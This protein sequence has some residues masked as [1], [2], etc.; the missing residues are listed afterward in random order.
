MLGQTAVAGRNTNPLASTTRLR[1][2]KDELLKNCFD[3]PYDDPRHLLLAHNHMTLIGRAFLVSPTW[4]IP[5]D[6]ERGISF[7]DAEGKLS[8]AAVAEHPNGKPLVQMLK[9]G[10]AVEVLA[11]P[12]EVEEPQAAAVISRA[13][14]K[15]HEVAL[16]TTEL[17]A[18]AT[19]KGEIIR[20]M[21]KD[22][23]QQ[24]AYQ[25]VRAAVA[26]QLDTALEDPDLPELFDY[27]INAGVGQN[28]YA[29]ELLDFGS[30]WVDSKHRQLRFA[31][32]A[33]INRFPVQANRGKNAVIKRAYR[34]KPTLGFC[35]TPESFWSY[36]G[37]PLLESLEAP[38]LVSPALH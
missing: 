29:D 14:Q 7:C 24:V 35:P 12:M 5:R 26:L 22:L 36:V 37:W 38:T 28:T 11:W 31:A 19:L 17:T 10:V 4:N 3:A 1:A 27:L 6:K 34:K 15:S 25:S 13:L 21:G 32:W 2:K 8:M 18:L 16:R 23:S 33:V 9:T 20:Q 30:T